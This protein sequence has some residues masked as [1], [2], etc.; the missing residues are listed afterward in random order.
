M[1]AILQSDIHPVHSEVRKELLKTV[2]VVPVA[3]GRGAAIDAGAAVSQTLGGGAH[4]GL[5]G[6]G[7]PGTRCLLCGYEAFKH[8]L[9]RLPPA[10]HELIYRVNQGKPRGDTVNKRVNTR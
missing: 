2:I 9:L 10:K 3:S 7:W 1:A 8:Q 4:A 5:R 6:N